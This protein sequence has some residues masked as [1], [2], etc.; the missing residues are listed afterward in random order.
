MSAFLRSFTAI[1]LT[2]SLCSVSTVAVAAPTTTSTVPSSAPIIAAPSSPWLTLSALSN[3]SAAASAA[4]AA[5]DD[6]HPGFP[7]LAPL[8]VILATI[9]V[10]AYVA[11]SDH[12]T[13]RSDFVEGILAL[14]GVS[15]SPA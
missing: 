9:A 6:A 5:Q 1:A 14:A 7:P 13:H 12:G 2:L 8:A 4:L 15:V 3:N 10:G 11:V